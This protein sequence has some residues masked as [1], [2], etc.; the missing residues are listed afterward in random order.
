MGDTETQRVGIPMKR[1]ALIAPVVLA[2]ITLAV[3]ACGSPQTANQAATQAAG[4]VATEAARLRIEM[5]EPSATCDG[6]T[7]EARIWLDSLPAKPV[8]KPTSPPLYVFPGTPAPTP[9]PAE[10]LTGLEFTLRFD[11]GVVW[12]QNKA[13]VALGADL[14]AAA[15]AGAVGEFLLPPP[16]LDNYEG[17]VMAGAVML[18]TTGA[19]NPSV[20]GK[21]ILLITVGLLP[22]GEGKTK[23][24]LSGVSLLASSYYAYPSVAVS[25]ATLE[26]AGPCAKRDTPTPYPK[27]TATPV[28]PPPGTPSSPPQLAASPVAITPVTSGVAARLDCPA[29]FATYRDTKSTFSV[30]GPTW[31]EGRAGIDDVGAPLINLG[32]PPGSQEPGVFVSVQV[33]S[34][35]TFPDEAQVAKLCSIGLVPAQSFGEEVHVTVAG[36]SAVGCHVVGEPHATEGPLE[37]FSLTALLPNGSPGSYLN[38]VVT[39]RTRDTGAKALIDQM[40][41]TIVVGK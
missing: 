20:A 7:R 30:C 18:G 14:R 40:L 38:V 23:L 5:A 8:A 2:V 4:T 3:L 10:G 12:V 22:V 31:L 25:D 19:V 26:V 11:P 33:T 29:D 41:S 24:T 17:T 27:A 35:G 21:S 28:P 16:R 9:V 34:R 15:G 13:D 39:W 32:T 1:I 36:L 37:E 6:R